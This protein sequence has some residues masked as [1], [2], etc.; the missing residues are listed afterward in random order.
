M[1]LSTCRSSKQLYR[2]QATLPI[3][4][5]QA[6]NEEKLCV[7]LSIMTRKS[8]LFGLE[9]LNKT[10]RVSP[11]TRKLSLIGIKVENNNYTHVSQSIITWKSGR[12]YCWYCIDISD[13]CLSTYRTR[14]SRLITTLIF[15]TLHFY[16]F[17]PGPR[18]LKPDEEVMKM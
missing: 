8:S 14:K 16:F 4:E 3:V 1:V 6:E 2:Q 5:K 18:A 9:A 12:V 11:I 13:R 17:F 10:S 15:W 7:S